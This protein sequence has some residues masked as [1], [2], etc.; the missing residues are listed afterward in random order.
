MAAPWSRWGT[1]TTPF[2]TEFLYGCN[3]SF[4]KWALE[5]LP[6]SD[7]FV[8][9]GYG[10]DLYVSHWARRKGSLVVDPHLN[11]R[12]YQTPVSRDRMDEVSYRQVY[13]HFYLLQFMGAPAYRKAPLPVYRYRARLC[14]GRAVRSGLHIERTQREHWAPDG[15]PARRA[16]RAVRA[17]WR[18]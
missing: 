4:R 13:N 15:R 12:H 16:G 17:R 10:E 18:S 14:L 11:V 6:D 7:V 9:H 2:E 3:M 8:G 1:A 5:G